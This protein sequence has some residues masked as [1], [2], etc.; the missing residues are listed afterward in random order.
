MVELEGWWRSG[1]VSHDAQ[2]LWLEVSL[3]TGAPWSIRRS[4]RQMVMIPSGDD[5]CREE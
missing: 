2:G 3:F 5:V 4:R 1:L